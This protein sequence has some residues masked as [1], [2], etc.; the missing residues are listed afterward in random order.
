LAEPT[1]EDESGCGEASPEYKTLLQNQIT[2]EQ[3]S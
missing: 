2:S 3:I 1:N